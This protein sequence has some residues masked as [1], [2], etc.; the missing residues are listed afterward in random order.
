MLLLLKGRSPLACAATA[1]LNRAK[2]ATP[3]KALTRHAA[4][5][6]RANS[7]LMLSAT[8]RVARA[9][10][11]RVRSRRLRKYVAP[12][13]TLA[14]TS[15]RCAPAARRRVL[16]TYSH[17]TGRAAGLM[18]LR[19]QV[20]FARL[21]TVSIPCLA[22]LAAGARVDPGLAEQCQTVGASMNLQKACPSQ[23]DKSCQVSCQDPT[24]S[25]Q[26]VVLQSQL[27]DGSPCG[28]GGSCQ[29]GSCKAGSALDTLKSWYRQNL[30]IA[31]PVTV[32]G[33]I[34]VLVILWFILSRE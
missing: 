25:N 1:S 30:Q 4:T 21:W 13:K 22:V 7:S 10:P 28:Y 26:C 20:A 8:P 2:S 17:Q 15:P 27:V 29:G 33:G 23:N 16:R 9:A 32:V 12:P 3:G 11:T 6:R 18:D 14:V 24:T 34:V 19:V 5:R 31:I